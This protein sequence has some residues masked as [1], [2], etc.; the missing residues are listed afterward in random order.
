[1]VQESGNMWS[2]MKLRWRLILSYMVPLLLIIVVIG[3]VNA[4]LNVAHHLSNHLNETAPVSRQVSKL[5]ESLVR[6]QRAAYAYILISGNQNVEMGYP[7][8]IYEQSRATANDA[9]ATLDKLEMSPVT[10]AAVNEYGPA[11]KSIDQSLSQLIALVDQGREREALELFKKGQTIAQA[12]MVDQIADKAV[13]A[14]Q[15][16]RHKQR[17]EVSEAIVSVENILIYATIVVAVFM[18]AFAVWMSFAL[19]RRISESANHIASASTQIASTMTEHEQTVSHQS[20]SVVETTSTVEEIVAS[21]RIT[22]EQAESAADAA[23]NAQET[24][25][26]GLE[27]ITQNES[28]ITELEGRMRAIA[29]QIVALSEQAAQ[30]GNISRLV[31]ELAGETNMLAL[32][33]AVEAA[34]AGEHGKGFSVVASEIRKLADQSKQSAERANQIVAD[35][36]KATNTMVMTAED[37]SKTSRNVADS[38]RRAADAFDEINKLSVAVYQ[39]AQQVLLNSKQQATALSQIDEAMK[40]IKL[41]AQEIAAGTAQA[42]TGVD[43]LTEVA[44]QLKQMV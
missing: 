17:E 29:E 33:A 27:V 4:R 2:Q 43:N 1:M 42:R 31:G 8:T 28:E 41:G 26:K 15:A 21:A 14:E 6:M 30:I 40:T 16:D 11:L 44:S 5:S 12:R 25:Q 20:A 38:V 22:S 32:N 19:S 23:K 24:T 36:Q 9:L 39:N 34:R 35:I 37:A 7:K 10:R 18:V 13:D 3:L